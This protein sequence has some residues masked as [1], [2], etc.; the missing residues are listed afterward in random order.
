MKQRFTGKQIVGIL[1][2]AEIP[3]VEILSICRK[4]GV[5]EV[6]FY[7]WRKKYGNMEKSDVARLKQLEQENARLKKIVAERDLEIDAVR[8]LLA[9]NS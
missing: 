3:G 4:Y 1:R 8:E 6:S 9:K 5:S 7:R 2:E